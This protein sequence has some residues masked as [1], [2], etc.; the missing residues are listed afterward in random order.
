MAVSAVAAS[1]R[2]R[3]QVVGRFAQVLRRFDR[4]PVALAPVGGQPSGF[5]EMRERR[6]LVV[7]LGG[8]PRERLGLSG[9]IRRGPGRTSVQYIDRAPSGE[10]IFL[11]YDQGVL[12]GHRIDAE[13]RRRIAACDLLVTSLYA[14][15]HDF[16]DSVIE[17]P[18]AGLRAADFSDPADFGR[19]VD[20]VE[21]GRASGRA[22]V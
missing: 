1:E 8:E 15:I 9:S 2:V 17:A 4:R 12:A 7:A 10:K 13:A 22:W 19:G 16:F 5:R 3:S 20:V 21:I 6:R 14:E 18:S 11:R